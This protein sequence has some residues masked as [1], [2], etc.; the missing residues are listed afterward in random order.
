M[1]PCLKS[2]LLAVLLAAPAWSQE[3][4]VQSVTMAQMWTQDTPGFDKATYTPATQYLGIDATNL[5]SEKLSLH[6]FGWGRA[7]LRDASSFDGSKSAGDLTY[8]YLQYRFAQANAEMKAG[9][10]MVTQ[11]GTNEMVDGVSARADL[12]GGL[13]VSAFAG[14]PVLYTWLTGDARTDYAKQRNIIFGTRL[15]LRLSKLGEV[16]VS[17]LQD[18]STA[19]KDLS[20]PST[21]DYTR[22]QMGFD[23][24][25][26]PIARI[27]IS[28]RTLFDLASHLPVT[29]GTDTP[30][31]IAEHD[32]T[33]RVKVMDNVFVTGGFI[34]RNFFA[35]FAGTNMPSLFHQD[36]KDKMR[37]QD[38][39]VIIGAPD[40]IQFVA[41]V[42]HT[43]RE[44]YG[45][46]IRFGGELRWTPSSSYKVMTGFGF[47]RITADHVL[48]V[49]SLYPYY[50]LNHNEYRAWIMAEKGAFSA[51]LDG[52]QQSYSDTHNPNLNGVSSIYEVV[53]SL[54][55]QATSSFKLSGDVSYGA[56]P[57]AKSETRGLLRAEFRFG[58]KG[59]QK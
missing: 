9:R 29:P 47:H 10:F 1:G 41:D 46:A 36:E 44:T 5:G 30:S 31:K 53:G 45:D 18:G 43:Y 16:G 57:L 50:S 4:T 51:S 20:T 39:S 14:V 49:D 37:A 11:S 24:H 21:V 8:G 6:L 3:I 7:D 55:W 59:G 26:V 2:G 25:L 22:K 56:N 32:Y 28:G 48:L 35:Y 33:L 23:L 40:A 34:Q 17:F 58:G 54:G 42:R 27:D 12:R 15:G 38:G 13:T 19:A 52:I